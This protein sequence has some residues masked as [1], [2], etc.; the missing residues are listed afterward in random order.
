ML[1]LP[2]PWPPQVPV[3]PQSRP[4]APLE[5][6]SQ[7]K[8]S[9]RQTRSGARQP[10]RRR[11]SVGG[12]GQARPGD[13]AR[14]PSAALTFFWRTAWGK[15]QARCPRCGARTGQRAQTQ[16][17]QSSQ[18]SSSSRH[19]W[20]PHARTPSEA[21]AHGSPR[22]TAPAALDG[23]LDGGLGGQA[24][25]AA[26][27]RRASGACAWGGGR[28]IVRRCARELPPAADGLA[29]P[30]APRRGRRGRAGPH[31]PPAAAAG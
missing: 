5:R 27:L 17:S 2:A 7:K 23:S 31:H 26:A 19:A 30:R 4:T 11:G 10:R 20:T 12:A 13:I 15:R 24:G 9:P 29:L 6:V 22:A 3:I 16:R 8:S 25:G 28:R 14:R 18:N 21:E 1:Q